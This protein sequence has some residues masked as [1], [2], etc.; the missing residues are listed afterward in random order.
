MKTMYFPSIYR[1]D[2][3]RANEMNT[4]IDYAQKGMSGE[5]YKTF[6]VGVTCRLVEQML[7]Y[8]RIYVDLIDLPD[9]LNVLEYLDKDFLTEVAQKGYISFVNGYDTTIGVARKKLFGVLSYGN[10][11][12]GKVNNLDELKEFVFYRY[13]FNSDID[14]VLKHIFDN[15]I[16]YDK[17]DYVDVVKTLDNDIK[18]A[19]VRQSL[20]IKS[21]DGTRILSADI[22]TINAMGHIHKSMK[23][24]DDL[25]IGT[26]YTD[27]VLLDIYEARFQAHYS[28]E[29]YKFNQLLK[30]YNL[31][32]IELLLFFQK[33][34]VG[35]VLELKK[36]KDFTKLYETVIEG[37]E[38]D[39]AILNELMRATNNRIKKTDYIFKFFNLL[40]STV[41]GLVNPFAGIGVA[42]GGE[43]IS[44]FKDGRDH[45]TLVLEKVSELIRSK[46]IDIDNM[47]NVV[48]SRMKK[49]YI[50]K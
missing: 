15:S 50:L 12:Y 38:D 28:N 41:A 20:G 29:A 36:S 34:N 25:G 31:P 6:R 16:E 26:L 37:T 10:S 45:P 1:L 9:L 30:T 35:D 27:D 13:K 39:R 18:N 43:V 33:M 42:L 2:E 4:K 7:Y 8:D 40:T 44:I 3:Y 11:E 17:K 14:N 49:H 48:S 5:V 22:P 32:D 23:T 46:S 24:I 47:P 19:S 21:V